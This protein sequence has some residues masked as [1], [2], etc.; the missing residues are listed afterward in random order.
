M[1]YSKIKKTYGLVL[2]EANSGDYD[3]VITILTADMGKI[4][5]FAKGARRPKSTL[6]APTQVFSFSNFVLYEGSTM[7]Y[8]NSA[9][10]VDMFYDLRFSYSKMDYG[11]KILKILKTVSPEN[12]EVYS[13]LK[14]GILA[15]NYL[16]KTD[17]EP[18]FIYSIFISRLL[19]EMGYALDLKKSTDKDKDK[20]TKKELKQEEKVKKEQKEENKF[21]IY[22][23]NSGTLKEYRYEKEEE[24]EKA[25]KEA[26][27]I[28]DI[29]KEDEGLLIRKY[30]LNI[31]IYTSIK[32]IYTS[33]LENIFNFNLEDDVKDEFIYLIKKGFKKHINISLY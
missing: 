1:S 27:N 22:L 8:I 21:C 24:K 7:Y 6:L 16:S 17:K 23:E 19:F 18:E 28:K 29:K 32:Y 13:Y 5:A 12:Y 20:K 10:I 25:K 31:N 3:K 11:F 26:I 15:L 9:S 2:S 33:D 14:L 4:T 30:L